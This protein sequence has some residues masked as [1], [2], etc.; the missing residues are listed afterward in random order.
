MED[1]TEKTC[2]RMLQRIFWKIEEMREHTLDEH[3]DIA[4]ELIDMVTLK[5]PGA[6][7]RYHELL[8]DAV[9]NLI[10]VMKR[11]EDQMK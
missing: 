4:L 10:V 1:V 2:K 8:C 9:T 3:L 7:E 11:L 6:N 5:E